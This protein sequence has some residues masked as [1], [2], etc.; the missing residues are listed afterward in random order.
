MFSNAYAGTVKAYTSTKARKIVKS[1]FI[2]PPPLV[3]F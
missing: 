3:F 1:L 2:I